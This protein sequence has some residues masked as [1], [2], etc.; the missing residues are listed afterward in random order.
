MFHEHIRTLEIRVRL[1]EMKETAQQ[2]LEAERARRTAF[3]AAA[4]QARAQ[5]QEIRAE[6]RRQHDLA[7]SVRSRRLTQIPPLP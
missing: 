4:A 6:M 7:R 2:E 5:R 1:R 3:K